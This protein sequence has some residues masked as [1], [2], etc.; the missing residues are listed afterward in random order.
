[1]YVGC[2]KNPENRYKQHIS[3]LDKWMTPKRKWLELLFEKGLKPEMKVVEECIDNGREIEQF[4]VYLHQN[5]ITNIHNP[6]K[7]MK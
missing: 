6:E 4:H 1:L 5:T 7:G 2:T 3:K